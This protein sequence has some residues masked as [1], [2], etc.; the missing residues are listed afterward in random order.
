MLTSHL[1]PS[2]QM[3]AQHGCDILDL[4]AAVLL[5]LQKQLQQVLYILEYQMRE[6]MYDN[7]FQAMVTYIFVGAFNAL[8]AHI[9]HTFREYYGINVIGWNILRKDETTGKYHLILPTE[10]TCNM[11]E[12]FVG[13]E[14]LLEK[15]SAAQADAAPGYPD[16]FVVLKGENDQTEFLR[17]MMNR[18]SQSIKSSQWPTY[19]MSQ[20]ESEE[21]RQEDPLMLCVL[22]KN[23]G[24]EAYTMRTWLV[25]PSVLRIIKKYTV[26]ELRDPN[27]MFVVT[28]QTHRIRL[29]NLLLWAQ[30][31]DRNPDRVLSRPVYLPRIPH[32]AHYLE[33]LSDNR[34]SSTIHTAKT[35]AENCR[36]SSSSI[37]TPFSPPRRSARVRSRYSISSSGAGANS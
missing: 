18:V 25:F 14:V 3:D 2:C 11:E 8:G 35:L 16:F 36:F 17:R 4:H 13:D 32:S 19:A 33:Q 7:M 30:S 23:K 9:R 27:G 28:R 10:D 21:D 6:R 20:L 24:M 22:E 15:V 37:D 31:E 5:V 34:N 12:I 1:N 29:V 26:E